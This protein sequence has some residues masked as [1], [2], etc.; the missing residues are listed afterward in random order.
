MGLNGTQW[1]SMGSFEKEGFASS[2]GGGV[3]WLE[4]AQNI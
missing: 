2:L 1:D 4:K 3:P